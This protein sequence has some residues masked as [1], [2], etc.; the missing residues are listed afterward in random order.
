M[1]V[2]VPYACLAPAEARGQKRVLAHLELELQTV[3]SHEMSAGDQTT[4][5][6]L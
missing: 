3:L 1:H 6:P 5:G 2:Y 4:S